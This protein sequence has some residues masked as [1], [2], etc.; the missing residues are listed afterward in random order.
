MAGQTVEIVGFAD[1]LADLKRMPADM[2]A[3]LVSEL[4]T[5]AEIVARSAARKVPTRTGNAIA[6]IVS[7][8]STSGASVGE[9]GSSAPYM[10]WLDFGSRTPRTGNSR[11][12]GP[13]RGSGAGPKGGRFIYPAIVEQSSAVNKAMTQAVEKASKRAGFH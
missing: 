5:V 3:E 4:K 13:W 7:K 2:Q 9:G 1:F 10:K 6:S 11:M 8:G 12:E